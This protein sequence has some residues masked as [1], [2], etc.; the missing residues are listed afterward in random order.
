MIDKIRNEVQYK[1]IM[2]LIEAHIKKATKGGGFH[3][4]TKKETLELTCLTTMAERYEDINLKIMPMPVTI[5]AVI[6]QKK[7]ELEIT[8]KILAEMLG[9]GTAKLSQILSGKR[10]PDVPFLKAVHE[11]LGIDGNFILERV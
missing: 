10:E 1:Q 11:K 6:Q 7:T 9:I 5:N 2:A 3:S 4:L 8:Q